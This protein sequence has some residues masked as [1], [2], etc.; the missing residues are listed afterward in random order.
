LLALEQSTTNR[1]SR[2][3]QQTTNRRRQEEVI[4]ATEEKTYCRRAG[5]P[6]RAQQSGDSEA[7]FSIPA[8]CAT[9]N[10]W[11][12][13]IGR[14]QNPERGERESRRQAP[15]P[16]THLRRRKLGFWRRVRRTR[17]GG[18]GRRT[19]QPGGGRTERGRRV[20]F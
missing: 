13:R 3:R 11:I 15:K 6:Q 18:K 12:G 2:T 4:C 20:F 5:L 8:A 1:N 10:D 14:G 17:R 16:P 19:S 9:H 7:P